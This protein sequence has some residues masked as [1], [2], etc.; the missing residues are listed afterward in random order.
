MKLI[1]IILIYVHRVTSFCDAED[2]DDSCDV[3]SKLNGGN[4]EIN[5]I[6]IGLMADQF[7]WLMNRGRLAVQQ[8]QIIIPT[9]APTPVP[10]TS[11]NTSLNK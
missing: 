6:N 5:V 11:T 10:N 7:S 1:L 4:I 9:R 8:V 2:D 3:N